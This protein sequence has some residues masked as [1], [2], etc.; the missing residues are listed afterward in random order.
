M[1]TPGSAHSLM[2]ER[3]KNATSNLWSFQIC[4]NARVKVPTT[5]KIP[6]EEF[7]RSMYG[8][9]QRVREWSSR[10]PVL[11]SHIVPRYERTQRPFAQLH[12][13]ESSSELSPAGEKD[14][15]EGRARKEFYKRDNK[16]KPT[17]LKGP[18][19]GFAHGPISLRDNGAR[20]FTWVVVGKNRH[21]VRFPIRLGLQVH[22]TQAVEHIWTKEWL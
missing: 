12:S 7:S 3:K 20:G 17:S 5:A 1:R 19:P 22:L 10:K 9:V 11:H 18:K 2:S 6:N 4:L 14:V 21:G 16:Q 8:P 13:S 15:R